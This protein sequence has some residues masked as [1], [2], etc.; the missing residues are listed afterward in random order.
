M[1]FWEA[2][3]TY[4]SDVENDL[5]DF[6]PFGTIFRSP[7]VKIMY[8][9][10]IKS[11]KELYDFEILANENLFD[12]EPD[13]NGLYQALIVAGALLRRLDCLWSFGT[14]VVDSQYLVQQRLGRSHLL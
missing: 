4:N 10:W 7:K 11:R 5:E 13:E 1:I 8:E 9:A 12:E 14:L 6:N 2:V 3:K